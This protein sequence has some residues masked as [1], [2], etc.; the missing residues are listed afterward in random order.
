[1]GSGPPPAG[2]PPSGSPYPNQLGPNQYPQ[3]KG[4]GGPGG[5][6]PS[7]YGQVPQGYGK[8]EGGYLALVDEDTGEEVGIVDQ[9]HISGIKPGSHGMWKSPSCEV[10]V[11]LTICF[12]QTLS[13]SN[14]RPSEVTE[15]SL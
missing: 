14:Y 8:G 4:P 15:L 6:D 11:M 2:P 1:M 5:Y 9:V 3:E 13:R 10:P 12:F 7:A